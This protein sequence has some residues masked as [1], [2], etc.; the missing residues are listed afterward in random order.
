[1]DFVY[2]LDWPKGCVRFM[3]QI[4]RKSTYLVEFFNKILVKLF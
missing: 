4:Y 2:L 1:M 3:L